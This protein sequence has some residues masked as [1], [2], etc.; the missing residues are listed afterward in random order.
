MD[1]KHTALPWTA[2]DHATATT[3]KIRAAGIKIADCHSYSDI[4]RAKMPGAPDRATR[5]AN[6]SFIVKAAN[7]HYELLDALKEGA[8]CLDDMIAGRG[9]WAVEDV[10]RDMRA[11]ISK[12]EGKS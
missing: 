4:N 1:T 8:E 3:A 5:A 2:D 6:A 7:C 11:A 9:G 10:L 12:A